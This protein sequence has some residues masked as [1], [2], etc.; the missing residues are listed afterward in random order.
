M[1]PDLNHPGDTPSHDD[2]GEKTM[3]RECESLNS[4][5]EVSMI[6]GRSAAGLA[7]WESD[8]RS[9]DT[10]WSLTGPWKR[11]SS[12]AAAQRRSAAIDQY[13]ES[14][15]IKADQAVKIMSFGD[16]RVLGAFCYQL[17]YLS[18]PVKVAA[19]RS[20][21]DQ[22]QRS[23]VQ[24]IQQDLFAAVTSRLDSTPISMTSS[25]T[26]DKLGAI[27]RLRDH[28]LGDLDDFLCKANG[29]WQNEELKE[30]LR[31]NGVVL[32]QHDEE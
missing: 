31:E 8:S 24:R 13:L 19:I 9:S 21:V 29:V 5:G 2:A 18:N 23:A 14:E 30:L 4:L 27:R 1:L 26:R 17:R 16:Q 3:L 6:S 28:D 32:D 11:R 25:H 10:L 20:A 22:A 12:Q 7:S 15:R